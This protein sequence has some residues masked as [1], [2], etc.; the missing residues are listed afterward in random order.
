MKA[1]TIKNAAVLVKTPGGAGGQ[2]QTR[3]FLDYFFS[4]DF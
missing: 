4:S 2:E 1:T 3:S